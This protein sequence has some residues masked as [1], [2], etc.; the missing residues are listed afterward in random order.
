METGSTPA[1]GHRGAA[2]AAMTGS[3][4]CLGSSFW[5]A[6]APE[7]APA[8]S[9][10][11]GTRSPADPSLELPLAAWSLA[12]LPGAAPLEAPAP[13]WPP[14]GTRSPAEPSPELPLDDC[15][16]APFGCV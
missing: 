10:P 8:A 15:S 1:S 11:A 5:G 6:L 12:G 14:A 9:P 4:Y 7:E 2:T 16:L 13:L 3:C